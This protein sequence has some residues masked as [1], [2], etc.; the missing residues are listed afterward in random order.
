MFGV[1]GQ[2]LG[3]SVNFLW[4]IFG[5]VGRR[6]ERRHLERL[7]LHDTHRNLSEIHHTCSKQLLSFDPMYTIHRTRVNRALYIFFFAAPDCLLTLVGVGVDCSSRNVAGA[8]HT[9]L[10]AAYAS[11]LVYEHR[12]GFPRFRLLR[13]SN[14]GDDV[15]SEQI[16][17]QLLL[18]QLDVVQCSRD[19]LSKSHYAS[20]NNTGVSCP[21]SS[22]SEIWMTLLSRMPVVY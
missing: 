12:A 2:L 22:T 6:R 15:P 3:A 11:K 1:L 17:I 5:V 19:G 14:F 4:R 10:F 13:A 21:S 8:C 20:F 18:F 9:R 16:L 7:T